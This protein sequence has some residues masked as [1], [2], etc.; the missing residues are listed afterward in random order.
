MAEL[1]STSLCTS[2]HT[3]MNCENSTSLHEGPSTHTTPVV[4]A[5]TRFLTPEQR[6]SRFAAS[7][8]PADL[9][10]GSYHVHPALGDSTIH[11]AAIQL[12]EPEEGLGSTTKVPVSVEAFTARAAPD[13]TPK[14][15]TSGHATSRTAALSGDGSGVSDMDWAAASGGGFSITGLA[16]K[17]M[18]LASGDLR[19]S[20]T[21]RC[22]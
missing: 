13:G 9:A 4:T 7:S 1:F 11:A 12:A 16:S 3:T 22:G 20:G 17:A 5:G 21:V 19:P 2:D 14:P 15:G 8:L 18:P 10:A 6:G